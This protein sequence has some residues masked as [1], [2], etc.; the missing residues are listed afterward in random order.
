MQCPLC[1]TQ[2]KKKERDYFLGALGYKVITETDY[3]CQK[4]NSVFDLDALCY[5]DEWEKEAKA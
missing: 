3:I 2:L 5:W 4:C 1:D